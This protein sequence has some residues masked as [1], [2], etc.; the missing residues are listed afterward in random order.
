M[1]NGN[2][3][4]EKRKRGADMNYTYVYDRPSLR[5]TILDQFGDEIAST[6]S[7]QYAKTIT[8]GLNTL[9]AETGE[10]SGSM[11]RRM[12][13]LI[14]CIVKYASRLSSQGRGRKDVI[15]TVKT[16]IKKLDG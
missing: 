7:E 8:E 14:Q 11:S 5:F 6:H 15:N 2:A 10:D 16:E 3:K 13:V 4:K 1:G 9:S 12:G